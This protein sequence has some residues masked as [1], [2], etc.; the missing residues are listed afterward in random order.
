VLEKSSQLQVSQRE[1][2]TQKG[3]PQ[4]RPDS[5]I[6]D[7]VFLLCFPPYKVTILQGM[8]D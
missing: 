4:Q 5:S 7:E 2:V 3:L 1:T 8:L 6:A